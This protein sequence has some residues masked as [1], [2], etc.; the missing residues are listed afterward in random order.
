MAEDVN[1]QFS[2][3]GLR[4]PAFTKFSLDV[5]L[6]LQLRQFDRFGRFTPISDMEKKVALRHVLDPVLQIVTRLD[7]SDLINQGRKDQDRNRRKRTETGEMWRKRNSEK[8]EL[9][10]F[11]R[12]VDFIQ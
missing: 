11:R 7:P 6:C 2:F 10:L 1:L 8:P 3:L 4:S 12:L 5:V 9:E